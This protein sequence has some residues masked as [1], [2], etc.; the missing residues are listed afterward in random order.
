MNLTSAHPFWALSNG[1]VRTYPSLRQDIRC[2]VVVVGGGIT[3]AL[4]A[5]HLCEAGVSTVLIDKRDIG[6]GS[7]SASTGL[8]QYEIDVPLRELVQRVGR[9]AAFRSVQLCCEAITK[10]E[11]LSLRRK[12]ECGFRRRP[13]L[14]MARHK[15]EILA[16]AEEFQLRPQAGMEL[17]MFDADMVQERFPFQRPAALFSREGGQVDPHRLTH[18]LQEP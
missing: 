7:T 3:G 8:L 14:F 17:V 11:R 18:G 16:F 9:R 4:V 12:I 1:L 5:L 10:L 2:D 6:T 15:S 13:S